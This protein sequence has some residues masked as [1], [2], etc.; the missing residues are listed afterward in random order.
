MK[1]ADKLV[2]AKYDYPILWKGIIQDWKQQTTSNAAWLTYAANYLVNTGG[3]HWAV[4]PF[5]MSTRVKGIEEPDFYNDLASLDFVLLSHA[6]SDHLDLN[7]INALVQRPIKW[8]IPQ[9]ML[10]KVLDSSGIKKENIII[11]VNGESFHIR[12][13]TIT[14]FES[15]H[16]HALGGI[17]ETGYLTEFNK[18]RWLF[19]GDIRN[20]EINKLPVFKKL[21]GVFAHLWLGKGKAKDNR[22]KF[23]NEF[24]NFHASLGPSKLIITHLDEFGRAEEELWDETHYVLVSKEFHSIAPTMSVKMAK[25]GMKVIL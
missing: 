18:K 9:H 6:H 25:M 20:F 19:P 1:L 10:E 11:P 17:E 22:P 13:I 14:P 12:N 7:L 21:D 8:V 24:V 3:I 16:F 5:S 15:L 23:M 2:K 4:D